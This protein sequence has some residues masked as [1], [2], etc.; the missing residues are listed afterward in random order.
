M[1]MNMQPD[2]IERLPGRINPD[3]LDDRV[4]LRLSRQSLKADP[5]VVEFVDRLGGANGQQRTLWPV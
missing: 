4:V 2:R 1:S 3:A 5:P